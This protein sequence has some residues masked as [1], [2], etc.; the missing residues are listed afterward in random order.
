M[1]QW[2]SIASAPF[3]IDLELSVIERSEVHALM[4]PCRRSMR[5]WINTATKLPVSVAPTHWRLWGTNGDGP[6]SKE[7]GTTCTSTG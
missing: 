3:A 4:F 6:H 2:H 7:G 1:G 5:G